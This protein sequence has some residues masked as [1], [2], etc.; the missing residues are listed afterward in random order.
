M[1]AGV[2]PTVHGGTATGAPGVVPPGGSARFPVVPRVVPADQAGL[3]EAVRRL[4]GGLL[5]AF[6][7][8][9]VYGLGADATDE[10][11]VASI[12][13]AKGRPG[14]NPLIVHVP[15]AAAARR[16][17]ARWDERADRLARAF[18][19]GPLTLVVKRAPGIATGVGGG[20]DTVALRVPDHPVALALLAAFGHPVA[21][22][23]ANRSGRIS[24]TTAAH[25]AAETFESADLLVLDG[26]PCRVGLESTVLDLTG[27]R[28]AILRP[29]SIGAGDLLPIVG[30][31]ETTALAAQGASPGT[32]ASHYAPATPA[33]TVAEEAIERRL[34]R[35]D[36]PVAVIA[37]DGVAVSPAPG[38]RFLRLPADP[39]GFARELYAAMRT[40]DDGSC[41]RIVIAT[42]ADPG[43]LWNAVRDRLRR[44][45][46]RGPGRPGRALTG[47]TA[48]AP[49]A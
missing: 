48:R 16:A 25:V 3:E 15:D 14:D 42:P 26:G 32:G 9:T 44:A 38:R 49:G 46:A 36:G 17:A 28:P 41:A 30:P 40:A 47:P 7:T 11:A 37:R 43:H 19:P 10:A 34:A 22:P 45:T 6:P 20:R 27:E 29:G 35:L 18:W 24:P 5:V 33:E 13:R 1:L 8:E 31:V 21:A 39:A 2:R 4:A 23:S 12:F